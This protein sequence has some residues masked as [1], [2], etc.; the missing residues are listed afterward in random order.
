VDDTVTDSPVDPDDVRDAL[1]RIAHSPGFQAAPQV[2]E[3]LVYVVTETLAGRGGRL[4]ERTVARSALGRPDTFDARLDPIVRVQAARVRAALSR[5][6]DADGADD[7]VRIVLPK[8]TY[9][10]E[11]VA[12]ADLAPPVPAAI[13]RGPGIVVLQPR[14]TSP[15]TRIMGAAL[16]DALVDALSEFAGVRVIGPVVLERDWREDLDESDL[17][18]RFGGQY[19]LDGSILAI[20]PIVRLSM[21][22]HESA[23]RRVLWSTTRDVTDIDAGSLGLLDDTAISVA[24]TIADFGGVVH[25]QAYGAAEAAGRAEVLTAML[26]Y[27]AWV[28]DL[29]PVR[30]GPTW[31]KLAAARTLEPAN[32]LLPAMMGLLDL[33]A[34]QIGRQRDA[35][36][37]LPRCEELATTSLALDERTALGH[38]LM[39]GVALFRGQRDRAAWEAVRA[40]ELEPHHPA[41]QYSCG[42][43]LTGAGH[44]EQGIA[45]IRESV[46]LSTA[47]AGYLHTL[48]AMDG[49]LAGEAEEALAHAQRVEMPGSAWPS[50][51]RALAFALLDRDEPA[52]SELAAALEIEPRIADDPAAW[53]SEEVY[54]PQ[55]VRAEVAD[56]IAAVLE[57]RTSLP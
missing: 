15:E 57:R 28:R 29:E 40:S 52:A 51:L 21:T 20:D 35:A 11:F 8:G 25:R 45:H 34:L 46:R 16:G 56:L 47:H 18:G 3:F 38:L 50:L 19:I 41:T 4:K 53:L 48:L 42:L 5:Y 12:V 26:A 37:V 23:S 36:E 54:V 6:Y 2:R 31:E 43:L 39:G 30:I 10:P 33:A 7:P 9:A 22:L 27:Y 49:I 55:D 24:A 44:W 13:S 32:P 14:G 1:E 17:A